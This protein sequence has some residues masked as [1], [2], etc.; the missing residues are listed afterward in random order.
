MMLR[1][2][3]PDRSAAIDIDDRIGLV[4]WMLSGAIVLAAYAGL[5]TA[6]MS[7]KDP[8]L[9]AEPFGGIVIELSPL[10][11]ATPEARDLPP[12]PEQIE[13][14]PT[15]EQKIE[16]VE[17][18]IETDIKP[19]PMAEVTVAPRPVPEVQKPEEVRPPAPATTAPSAPRLHTGAAPT[20]PAI[21]RPDA[22]NPGA[23]I[24][25]QSQV[26]GILERNKRYPAEA[27]ARGEQG[28][29]QLA[30]SLDRQ[31]RVVASRITRSSGSN[32]LDREAR[33]LLQRAQPF[34]P[35]PAMSG[36]QVDLTVPIRF[37]I[38]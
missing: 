18:P 25:W 24:S 29:A 11:V 31:G 6:L 12:G 26:V 34:P 20:A 14:E 2:A 15:P 5:L 33:D 3:A 28:V 35:P 22:V 1:A 23:L 13:A 36:S 37:N 32:A 7:W 38:R 9:P 4:R 10:A 17:A 8:I 30:F 27:R 19:S 21:A 16:R